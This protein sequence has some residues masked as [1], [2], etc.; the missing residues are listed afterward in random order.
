MSAINLSKNAQKLLA[1]VRDG[2][3]YF[4]FDARTPKAMEELV[5]AGLVGTCGRAVE[6]RACYVPAGYEARSERYPDE[7]EARRAT[8]ASAVLR[9]IFDPG[10]TAGCRGERTVTQ[11]QTDAVL[12]TIKEAGL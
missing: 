9:A 10:L 1:R 6:L 5:T 4:A 7:V 2:A 8:L 11:W 12:R 3:F